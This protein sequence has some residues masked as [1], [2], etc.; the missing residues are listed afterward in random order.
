MSDTIKIADL[1][2]VSRTDYIKSLRHEVTEV[3][4]I[5]K[6]PYYVYPNGRR[7]WKGQMLSGY[8][9]DQVALEKAIA[10]YL[11]DDDTEGIFVT[12]Q[13]CDPR[14]MARSPNQLKDA[15]K[16]DATKNKDIINWCIFPIDV[17]F[18]NKPSGISATK[19]EL[20]ELLDIADDIQG[21]LKERGIPSYRAL[22]GNGYHILIYLEKEAVTE[23][24][25]VLVKSLADQ[26][27]AY[28]DID[29]TVYNPARIFKLY[30]T[31]AR[32]GSNFEGRQHRMAR[33]RLPKLDQIE[34]VTLD[35]LAEVIQ[36]DLPAV[37][38]QQNNQKNSAKPQDGTKR[39][40]G[41]TKEE[42]RD[43]AINVL[44]IKDV[45]EWK[46]RGSYHLAHCECPLCER[47]TVNAHI[48]YTKTGK[49]GLRC[50]SNSCSGKSLEDLYQMKGILKSREQPQV[51]SSKKKDPNKRD[52]RL[53]MS[54]EELK[55]IADKFVTE[56]LDPLY[57]KLP[58]ITQD[59]LTEFCIIWNSKLTE[60]QRVELQMDKEQQK[61]INAV[62]FA[63]PI[64]VDDQNRPVVYV[65]QYN[66]ELLKLQPVA[67]NIV[68]DQVLEGLTKKKELNLYIRGDR[69]GRVIPVDGG[70]YKWD[71]VPEKG[72]SRLIAEGCAVVQ[73]SENPKTAELT[74]EPIVPTP[75]W[76][77]EGIMSYGD[78]AQ[79]RTLKAIYTYPYVYNNQLVTDHGYHKK[80]K[81]YI[82]EGASLDI[83][84]PASSEEAVSILREL[85]SG[86]RFKEEADFENAIALALTPIIRPNIPA[87]CPLFCIT[88]PSHGSGKSFLCQT[89]WSILQGSAP[90]VT[91]LENNTEMEK[92]LFSV[93][94][95]AMPYVL[96]DNVDSNKPL[97]SGLL[98][99]F[100]TEPRRQAR[101]FYTQKT[102]TIE[103]FTIACYTGT[104][105]EASME[106]IDRMVQIRLEA[107]KDRNAKIHYKFDP[108]VDRIQKEQAKYLGALI[109]M[110]EKWVN[111]G[112]ERIDGTVDDSD[113]VHRQ[114]HWSSQIHGILKT[115]GL[116]TSFLGNDADMRKDSSPEDMEMS[117]FL[118]EIVWQLGPDIAM[119]EWRTKDVF[120]FA[121]YHDDDKVDPNFTGQRNMLSRW[122]TDN[123]EEKR[124]P[125]VGRLLN[126][127]KDKP[128]GGWIIQ[129]VKPEEMKKREAGAAFRLVDNGGLAVYHKEKEK[130]QQEQQA[131]DLKKTMKESSD[132]VERVEE[133]DEERK[134]IM[135]EREAIMNEG[136]DEDKPEDEDDPG[137]SF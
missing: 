99:S 67:E 40:H 32:K 66:D 131:H 31:Y 97:D 30:G 72:A 91:D 121:S 94:S 62:R 23:A 10:P 63:T 76:I 46:S 82:P 38:E 133:T 44:D 111:E 135:D 68:C 64:Y 96:F 13:E 17:D 49:P 93:I 2:E 90:A 109:F 88:A 35:K 118:K 24:N 34:C 104:S 101:L 61:K 106:L 71:P 15:R 59:E 136:W 95:D 54:E 42:W 12:V 128:F 132:Q 43:Y 78:Y 117:R 9:N 105:T 28:W 108:I 18:S 57:A 50:H 52:L 102:T 87:G 116:G 126:K 100:V 110:V 51:V 84:R 47:T 20:K 124:R 39:F 4:I 11:E 6:N 79:L 98:A 73:Y 103:N 53:H 65:N 86:F 75:R 48:T 81:I 122:I 27:V 123:H 14:L 16:D 29:S 22:S 107:P 129:K 74:S 119:E 25:T 85:L 69:L 60:D 115:N 36:A 41:D 127:F 21:W 83:I 130:L 3:R 137:W 1:Q 80:S 134:A 70:I 125:A 113:Q 8:F 7:E 92:K 33:L 56:H 26:I 89:V 114:R 55:N 112:C 45:T 37:E 120:H 5:R 58:D 19:E 77:C